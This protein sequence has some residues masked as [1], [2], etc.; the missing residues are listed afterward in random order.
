MS[1]AGFIIGAPGGP[2]AVGKY[3]LSIAE[4]LGRRGHRVRVVASR[5]GVKQAS[6]CNVEVLEWPSDRPTAISDALF[7]AKLI[8]AQRPHCLIAN[9]AAVNWMCLIGRA[10]GVRQRIAFYHTL[11]TQIKRDFDGGSIR[12]RMMVLR[13]RAVF[14]SATAIAGISRAALLDAQTSWNVPESKC[15]LWQYSMLD[16]V[17]GKGVT[18]P[19]EREDTI[20]CVAR[21][22]PSKGHNILL[23]ALA[24]IKQRLGAT[25]VLFFGSGPMQ[26]ELQRLSTSLGLADRCVFYGQVDHAEVLARL[27][28]AKLTAVPSLN[29]AFGLV[30][31]ESL[32]VGTPV[33]ASRID[34]I[35]EIIQDGVNGWLVPPGETGPLAQKIAETLEQPPLRAEL[36]RNARRSFLDH[37]EEFATLGKQVDHLEQDLLN[38]AG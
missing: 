32:A 23:H 2:G 12:A 3:F 7:L 1:G 24:S 30:N 4:E 21:F 33:V 20:A 37:F 19:E 36:S 29:E 13:K 10:Y 26:D 38:H 5:P 28:K 18:A 31:V 14:Q 22:N 27:S 16:P 15:Q 8:R 9:F 17:N 6:A 25:K 35:P 34:G 11:S